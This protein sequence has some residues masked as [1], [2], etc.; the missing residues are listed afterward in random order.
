MSTIQQTPVVLDE[1]FKEAVE[2]GVHEAY[3]VEGYVKTDGNGQEVLD[4]TALHEAIYLAVR[5][6]AV[7]RSPKQRSETALTKGE[8]AKHVFRNAPGANDEWD[9]L[10]DVQRSVWERLVR[11][12]WNPTN[13]NFSGPIQRI[14]GARDDK[15]VLIQ[16]KTTID[17]TPGMPCVYLTA[18]EELIFEDFVA[19]L[20]DS[21]RKAA[22]KLA[23]NGAMVS[24]RNKQLAQKVGREVDSGMKA[25]AVLAKSTLELMSGPSES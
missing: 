9:E 20:K 7:V 22:E 15:L 16:T 12:A 24:S 11:E 10:D 23:K 2:D 25:A 8:L 4:K 5:E 13:P 21:V 19:P 14:V 6:N 18:S 17:G 1:A 3:R